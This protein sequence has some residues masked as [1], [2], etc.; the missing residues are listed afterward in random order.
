[1]IAMEIKSANSMKVF[2]DGDPT[3]V[4]GEWRAWN[5]ACYAEG[6]MIPP[7]EFKQWS[8]DDRHAHLPRF[9]RME[10]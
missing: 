2:A 6:R 10:R 4:F 1:M 7:A 8:K 5:Y 9:K 3:F